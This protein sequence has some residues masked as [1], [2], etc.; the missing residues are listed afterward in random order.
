MANNFSF[1]PRDSSPGLQVIN[2]AFHPTPL[3]P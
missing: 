3:D 2:T 1:E